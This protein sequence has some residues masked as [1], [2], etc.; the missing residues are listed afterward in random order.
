MERGKNRF[1]YDIAV[2]AMFTAL[3]A[4]CSWLSVSLGD[5]PFTLQTFGV[6][7]A[8]GVLGAKRGTASVVT[9]ILLGAVGLP[10][11]H[12]FTGGF[13]IILGSTGGFMVGF[14]FSALLIGLVA[15]KVGTR[16]AHHA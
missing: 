3:I 6:F 12:G 10:V 7:C 2:T 9:Y 11:F 16:Q 8:A 13:G 1:I 14:I 15:D 5:V 4:V